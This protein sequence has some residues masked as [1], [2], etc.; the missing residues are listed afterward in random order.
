MADIFAEHFDLFPTGLITCVSNHEE[1]L[2][3]R[4]MQ[5]KEINMMISAA[6]ELLVTTV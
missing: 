3:Q 5:K 4:R 1:L 2:L 6:D